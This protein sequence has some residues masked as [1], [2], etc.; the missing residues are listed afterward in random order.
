MDGKSEPQW[1]T[2][3]SA[4]GFNRSYRRSHSA[5]HPC[6]QEC[7]PHALWD[8]SRRNALRMVGDSQHTPSFS[9]SHHKRVALEVTHASVVPPV[10]YFGR[11][12][13]AS[14]DLGYNLLC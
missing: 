11:D 6:P 2:A 1:G 7:L 13:V 5:S 10:V 3:S 12:S 14:C 8:R 9:Q 4:A